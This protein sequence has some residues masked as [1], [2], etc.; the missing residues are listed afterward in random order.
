MNTENDQ[1]VFPL[2]INENTDMGEAVI[3][4]ILR[5]ADL[6]IRIGNA[7]V[8]GNEI[9]QARCIELVVHDYDLF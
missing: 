2:T 3:L 8:F 6:L 7:E 1:D 5:V 4:Y 9:S